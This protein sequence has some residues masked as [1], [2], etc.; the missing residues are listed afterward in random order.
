[1]QTRDLILK[2]TIDNVGQREH[3]AALFVVDKNL[4]PPHR[5]VDKHGCSC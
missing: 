2:N 3:F 5:I 4:S 1:M